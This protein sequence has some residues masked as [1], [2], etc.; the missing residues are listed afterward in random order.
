MEV[1]INMVMFNI[2]DGEDGD[3]KYR[4][5]CLCMVKMMLKA[6]G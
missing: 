5:R 6:K 1:E 3:N 2:H 4:E